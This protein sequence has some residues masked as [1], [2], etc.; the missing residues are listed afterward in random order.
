MLSYGEVA[1]AIE[2][3]GRRIAKLAEECSDVITNAA[4]LEADFK[5]AF[6]R[7]RMVF[8]DD[9]AKQGARATVDMV[10]DHATIET[11]D[12]RRAHLIGQGSVTAIREALRASQSR[13][14][15]LRTLAAGYRQA[16]G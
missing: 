12:A 2:A 13:L 8:R 7:A 5:V 14:D 9:A 10:E 15:G 4:G 16:A 3:E 6:A 11:I 1:E